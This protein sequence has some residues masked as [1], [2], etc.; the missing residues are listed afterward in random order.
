MERRIGQAEG[1][2]L[3]HPADNGTTTREER[4]S[5]PKRGLTVI[6]HPIEAGEL[7]KRESFTLRVCGV[8]EGRGR[9]GVRQRRAGGSFRTTEKEWQ[10][11]DSREETRYS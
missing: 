2:R 1:G 4:S 7:G 5:K 9:K 11:T 3:I 10:S 6:T 8:K